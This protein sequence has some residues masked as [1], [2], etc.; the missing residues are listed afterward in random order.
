MYKPGSGA[1]VCVSGGVTDW[2]AAAG[3][4]LNDEHV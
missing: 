4:V 3:R 1:S 2:E